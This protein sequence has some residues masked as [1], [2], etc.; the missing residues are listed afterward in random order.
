MRAGPRSDARTIRPARNAGSPHARSSPASR[1]FAPGSSVRA[2]KRMAS[3]SRVTSSC[4]TTVSQPGGISAP[5]MMRTHCVASGV[6]GNGCPASAV[7]ATLKVSSL[8]PSRVP[9]DALAN[10]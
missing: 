7:P 5:V 1:R 10:A 6:P 9:I 8:A 2:S 3:P 4:G